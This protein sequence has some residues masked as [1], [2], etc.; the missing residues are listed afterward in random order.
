MSS[1]EPKKPHDGSKFD[2]TLE[3]LKK[4]KNLEG[5]IE[6]AQSNKR[7]TVAYVLLALGV[8]WLL[9]QPFYGGLLVGFIAGVY[10]SKD[11]AKFARDLPNCVEI[12]GFTKS[13]VA[14][15]TFL[16]LLLLS[17]GILVGAAISAAVMEFFIPVKK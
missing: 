13:V 10:F 5:A 9:F 11:L 15:A 7:D 6:Y 17:P 2:Q 16:A 14:G 4:N 8:F 3:K 12:F 1:D